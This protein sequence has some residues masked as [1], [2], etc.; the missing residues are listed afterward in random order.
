MSLF[1]EQ[2]KLFIMKNLLLF[3]I[4]LLMNCS[5]YGNLTHYIE[6]ST[7]IP[8]DKNIILNE[9]TLHL[10]GA[11]RRRELGKD[12]Y[13]IAHYSE[14]PINKELSAEQQLNQLIHS[15]SS[16]ALILKGV[17]TKIP[18]RGI[19]WAWNKGLK[20]VGYSNKKTKKNF[21]GVFNKSFTKGDEIIFE[22]T[23]TASL[24]VYINTKL[25]GEWQD[26]LLQKAIWEICLN[27]KSDLVNR[28]NLVSQK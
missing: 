26:P 2:C 21:V 14:K 18:A 20:D 1:K 27:E 13:A 10:T 8:F 9:N 11:D 12:V 7:Q 5:A 19:R 22:S 24:K 3:Y 16:K 15:S 4:L 6:P 17:N 28:K 25:I 23:T